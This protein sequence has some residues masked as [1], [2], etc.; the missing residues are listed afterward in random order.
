[1]LPILIKAYQAEAQQEIIYG[2]KEADMIKIP[3]IT[4]IIDRRIL[5]NFTIDADV[6]KTIVPAPFSPKIFNG[7]AIAGICLIR[8]KYMRPKGLPSFRDRIRKWSS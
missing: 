7:K 6:A 8:L 2:S 1:M 4:G 5:V 3:S